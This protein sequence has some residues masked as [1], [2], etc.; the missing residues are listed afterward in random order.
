MV[1]VAA[2][3]IFDCGFGVV[4]WVGAAG[5]KGEGWVAFVGKRGGM[6]SPV[7][8]RGRELGG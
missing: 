2:I 3:Q 6:G 5:E 1:V 4:A 8:G 7:V